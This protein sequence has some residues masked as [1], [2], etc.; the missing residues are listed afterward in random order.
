MS[1]WTKATPDAYGAAKVERLRARHDGPLGAAV[2]KFAAS[3]WHGVPASAILGQTASVHDPSSN[4]TD[5][6]TRQTFH[7]VGAFQ[8]P[9]G[10]RS[11]P[12]PNP[13]RDAPYNRWGA[14]AGSEL[15][16]SLLDRPA[17][18]TPDGWRA[19]LDDQAAV[20]LASLRRDLA[21]IT[22][23]LRKADPRLVPADE[24]S[25]YAVFL[26]FCA[27]S[28][29]ASGAWRRLK[30]AL[31]ACADV[32]E[33]VRVPAL[34][35]WIATSHDPAA[36]VAGKAGVARMVL[37]T[38]WKLRSGE[39]LERDLG[40]ASLAWYGDHDAGDEAALTRR[41]LGVSS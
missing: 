23:K 39:A 31:V 26:A 22:R 36:K 29:G 17:T 2:Q 11:G 12:A 8:T 16:V 33:A 37:R 24:G 34:V 21:R 6:A 28:R 4:T 38:L 30:P 20:G 5:T 18:M 35:H 32:P 14:L 9:A 15:V 13:K 40:G 27:F 41:A 19:A 7:E 25:L 10:L 3:A 1:D